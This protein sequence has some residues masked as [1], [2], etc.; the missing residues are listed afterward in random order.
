MIPRK[1]SINHNVR[2][3][4]GPV[5]L[6]VSVVAFIRPNK[7]PAQKT[8]F[9]DTTLRN[10]VPNLRHTRVQIGTQGKRF[11]RKEE[12]EFGIQDNSCPN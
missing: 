7:S 9:I 5:E 4:K 2:F 8:A 1:R 6:W 10:K 3:G 11:H 12:Y